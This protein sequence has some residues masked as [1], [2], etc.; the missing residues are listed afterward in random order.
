M[1]KLTKIPLRSFH[2]CRMGLIGV[3]EVAE[4]VVALIDFDLRVEK[5]AGF[6]KK[7]A[8]E[9]RRVAASRPR[10]VDVLTAGCLAKIAPSII[11]T[12]TV[13]MVNLKRV[14]ASHPLPDN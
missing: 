3:S 10:I 13:A 2:V 5:I 11:R 1:T 8:L 7:H 4:P 9:T 14:I 12:V 6:I